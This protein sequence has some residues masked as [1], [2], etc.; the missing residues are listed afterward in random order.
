[1]S[2]FRQLGRGASNALKLGKQLQ[3]GA[4]VFGRQLSNTAQKIG[5]GLEQAQRVVSKIEKPLSDIPVLGQ[6]VKIIGEGLGVGKNL[7]DIGQR[8]GG[9][10][11]ALSQGNVQQAI[12]EGRA[13]GGELKDISSQGSDILKRG[14]ELAGQVAM[15]V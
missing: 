14:G 9:A 5:S 15:F 10:I 11:R 12:K 6:G 7:A 4:N 13:I 2:F 3:S 8:G 1:M